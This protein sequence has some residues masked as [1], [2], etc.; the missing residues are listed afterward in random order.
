MLNKKG[1]VDTALGDFDMKAI[2]KFLYIIEKRS[3]TVTTV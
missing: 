3:E 2:S 1:Q